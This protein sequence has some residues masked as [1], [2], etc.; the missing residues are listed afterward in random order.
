[1]DTNRGRFVDEQHAEP[2]M[3]RLRVGQV[4]KLDGVEC[5]VKAFGPS[6][7]EVT[8]ELLSAQDREPFGTMEIMTDDDAE[9]YAQKLQRAQSLRGT[10]FVGG[11]PKR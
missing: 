9:V 4:V 5:R 8:L 3:K 11:A 1:M 10:G 2:W 7:R 6:D